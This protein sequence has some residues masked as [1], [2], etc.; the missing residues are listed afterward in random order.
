MIAACALTGAAQTPSKK[1]SSFREA[2]KAAHQQ[3][4][5]DHKSR[6]DNSVLNNII[7]NDI[8]NREA[9]S[10]NFSAASRSLSNDIITEAYRHLGK[11]YVWGAKGPSQFDCSGFTSYVYRQFGYQ[12]SPGSKTQYTQGR[13][14]SRKEIRKGD[15]V[16]FTSPRSGKGVG[17]VGICVEANGDGNFTFVHAS[18]K[19]VRVSSINEAYYSRRFIGARRV[20][21][22]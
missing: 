11:P 16:F 1:H 17:H 6:M 22:D 21:A 3:Q 2:H 18:I 10:S 7:S 15:L 14:I 19:G 5:A 12:I 8:Q 20:I 4:L 9:G 13:S